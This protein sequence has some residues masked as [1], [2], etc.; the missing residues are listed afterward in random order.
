VAVG[1]V[2]A[3]RKISQKDARTYRRR[4]VQTEEKVHSLLRC[5]TGQHIWTLPLNAESNAALRVTTGLGY[6][7]T[8]REENGALRIY[9]VRK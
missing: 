6:G 2:V 5:H 7:F 8:C 9:A 1:G 3:Y 4:A